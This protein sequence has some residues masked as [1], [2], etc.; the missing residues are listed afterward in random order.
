MHVRS[1]LSENHCTCYNPAHSL[2]YLGVCYQLYSFDVDFIE[3]YQQLRAT[4]KWRNITEMKWFINQELTIHLFLPHYED[5]TGATVDIS[6][7]TK[8]NH[9]SQLNE[10]KN[11]SLEQVFIHKTT[12]ENTNLWSR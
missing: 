4:I 11:I 5:C 3:V 7:D 12:K 8:Q 10:F 9:L 6:I 2:L 1:I